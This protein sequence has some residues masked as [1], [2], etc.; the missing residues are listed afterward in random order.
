[1]TITTPEIHSTI[2]ETIIG[3]SKCLV[4]VRKSNL[5]QLINSFL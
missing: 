5:L 1:M 3:H 4:V 2:V